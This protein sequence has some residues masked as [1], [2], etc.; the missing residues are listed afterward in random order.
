MLDWCILLPVARKWWRRCPLAEIARVKK[1]TTF[2]DFCSTCLTFDF[3]PRKFA[4]SSKPPSRDDHNVLSKVT[5]T[6]PGCY[7]ACSRDHAR[8]KY[9]AFMFSDA[10]ESTT[11]SAVRER[12][13]EWTISFAICPVVT[14]SRKNN[15][16]L[17]NIYKHP[18]FAR[19]GL[20]A[21]TGQHCGLL[22]GLEDL[23]DRLWKNWWQFL[24]GWE[25]SAS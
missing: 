9:D 3:L 1:W 22:P 4:A 24:V 20:P 16:W 6:W 14:L 15:C 21:A 18:N 8:S 5:T 25:T 11:T 10:L 12:L 19:A 7:F 13:V 17:A 23:P 2:E